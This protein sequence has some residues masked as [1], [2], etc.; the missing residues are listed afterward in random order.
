[1][2]ALSRKPSAR[3]SL[4]RRNS[5][6]RQMSSPEA[7]ISPFA[8]SPPV[9]QRVSVCPCD[10]GCPRCVAA[11]QPKLTIGRPNDKYEQEADR[12][13]DEVMRMP[14]AAL[15][16]QVDEEEEEGLRTK[17][18]A[19]KIAPHVQRQVGPEE[20]EEPIQAKPANGATVQRQEEE[21]EEEEEGRLQTKGT[22]KGVAAT[23]SGLES[24]V[25]SLRGSGEPL[26]DTE[27]TFFESR[28]GADFANVRVHHD[29]QSAHAARR[30]NA[31]AYTLGHD[32]VFGAGEYSPNSSSG[33]KLLAHELT[34]V[35]Q[36]RGWPNASFASAQAGVLQRK[37]RKAAKTVW[38]QDAIDEDATTQKQTVPIHS[39][40]LVR[41]VL[42]LAK[43]IDK[44]KRRDITAKLGELIAGNAKKLPLI[45][46]SDRLIEQMHSR[47][48]MLDMVAQARR[49]RRWHVNVN[50]VRWESP[51]SGRQEY[52]TEDWLFDNA[53]DMIEAAIKPG[54][55]ASSL[56][57]LKG[58]IT[59]IDEM[60]KEVVGLDQKKLKEDR[61]AR[62]E[63]SASA[64][65]MAWALWGRTISVYHEHL[66]E[67]IK[68]GFE[69]SMVAWQAVLQ[70]AMAD[71]EKGRGLKW[72]D[73]L[74][75]QGKALKAIVF[76]KNIKHH[77]GGLQVDSTRSD[78]G[79]TKGKHLDRFLKGKAAKRRS[80][81]IS[82]YDREFGGDMAE[83]KKVSFWR[84][85]T[86]RRQQLDVLRRIY[87]LE[88]KA[89]HVTAE[90]K[91][92]KAAITSGL[93]GRMRLHNNDDW[94]R[95]VF[96]KF[97]A[98]KSRLGDDTKALRSVIR[99][100]EQYLAAF[101]S[102][103]PYNIDDFGSSYLSKSFPRDLTGRLIHDCGVYALRIAYILSLVRR[104]L[105]LRFRMIALPLHVGLVITGPGMPLWVIHNNAFHEFSPSELTDAKN[106]WR[107]TTAEGATRKAVPLKEP[108]FVGEIAARFFV[109]GTDSPFKL[110]NV[111]APPAGGSRHKRDLWRF[112]T[113]ANTRLFDKT[114]EKYGHANY[115]FDLRYLEILKLAREWHNKY[116]VRFWNVTAPALWKKHSKAILL[117]HANLQKNPSDAALRKDYNKA[118]K[119]YHQELEA[120]LQAVMNER[121]TISAKQIGTSVELTKRAKAKPGLLTKGTR[122]Q[123]SER[124]GS[125]HWASEVIYNHLRIQRQGGQTITP[126]FIG[127]GN[128]VWPLD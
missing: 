40:V 35:L 118:I 93:R 69:L 119:P 9:I 7:R 124:F 46:P 56:K 6:P 47:L 75:D 15:Q 4:S 31:R 70:H 45:H 50:M 116:L 94:R 79:S 32:V 24:R 61:K 33:R 11:I 95:F 101:T 103:T 86:V 105:K 19:E 121:T 113:R 25:H 108:Q 43:A 34:H 18:N 42:D 102:H 27:R 29:I 98:A 66:I 51:K 111:P 23:G 127:D 5:Q 60:R 28:F 110:L 92:N 114:I 48:L 115:Q 65:D 63:F 49:L 13:A 44:E 53:L 128:K 99:L 123:P 125:G 72:L 67:S 8:P 82:F 14:E 10:G 73:A 12:I 89:G 104:Q 22:A 106:K 39:S 81:G 76:P 38:Y 2:K 36:Q 3:E 112:Y 80:V 57:A 55:P 30:I 41:V 54:D 84:A 107:E 1:M 117:A 71:L 16:R 91:E 59:A 120:A 87:G 85:L 26:P 88:K 37:R 74:E 20:E 109:P 96:E 126:P 77:I 83:E 100:L 78:F 58:S 62:G 122:I 90:S 97:K 68:R 52:T 17:P 64:G 21:S